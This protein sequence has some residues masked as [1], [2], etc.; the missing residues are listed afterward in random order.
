MTNSVKV[1]TVT[2][3]AGSQYFIYGAMT[4]AVS[5]YILK[6]AMRVV[7]QIRMRKTQEKSHVNPY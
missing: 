3:V 7:R 6:Q 4:V 5:I 1:Q 2:Q